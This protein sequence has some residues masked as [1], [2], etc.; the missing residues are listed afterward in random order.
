MFFQLKTMR[1]LLCFLLIVAIASV[2]MAYPNAYPY[3]NPYA[4]PFADGFHGFGREGGDEA[5]GYRAIFSGHEG[6][7][8]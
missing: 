7:G 6:G 4:N 1:F 8:N 3:A 5:P 2:A